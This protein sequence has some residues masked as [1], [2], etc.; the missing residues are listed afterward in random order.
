M[1]GAREGDE[2]GEGGVRAR[3]LRERAEGLGDIEPPPTP[4]P[5]HWRG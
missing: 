4:P 3:Q 5:G 2:E 1:A